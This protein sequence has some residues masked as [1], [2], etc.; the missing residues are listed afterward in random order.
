MTSRNQATPIFRSNDGISW[1]TNGYYVPYGS[2]PYDTNPYDLTA[3]YIAALSL[4]SVAFGNGVFVAVGQ[5]IVTSKDTYIWQSTYKFPTVGWNNATLVNELYGVTYVTNNNFTGFVAVGKG[6]TYDYSSGFS[7]IIDVGIILTSIDGTNWNQ[8]VN[9]SN[10]GLYGVSS[11][12]TKIVAVGEDGII[13]YS[14]NGT[15]WFGITQTQ[16]LSTISIDNVINVDSTIGLNID[17]AIRFNNSFS[18]VIAN[19][20][21]Y[22]SSIVSNTQVK[23]KTGILD[24]VLTLTV[25]SIPSNTYL[26]KYPL[27]N[28]L[29]DIIF[30]NNFFLAVGDGGI[31]RSSLDGF[32]WTDETSG[33]TENLNGITYKVVASGLYL[34]LD[35]LPANSYMTTENDL[36]M[37]T[38]TTGAGLPNQV[39]FVVVGDNNTIIESIDNGITWKSIS[40]FRV[41]ATLYDVQGESFDSGYSPEE[42]VSGVV[43]DNLTMVIT[44]K[45][46][47]NWPAYEYA[48]VGYN[49]VSIELTPINAFQFVYSFRDT[50]Q[51]PAQISLFIID[52]D[53]GLCT[54]LLPSQYTINWISET[55]TLATPLPFF[56]IPSKLRIDVYEVGNGNQLIRSSTKTDPILLNSVTGW[57][58]IFLNC[59]YSA[60]IF[61]GS[62]VLRPDE[63]VTDVIATRTQSS[64]DSIFVSDASK[65]IINGV[66]YFQGT[67]FGNILEDTPYYVKSI[68][69]LTNSI[70]I[71]DNYSIA[72]GVAGAIFNLSNA[73]GSMG[74]IIASGSSS[75]WTDPIILHNGVK[76]ALGVVGNI[77]RTKSSNNAITTNSTAGLIENSPIK[78]ANYSFGVIVPQQTYYIKNILDSNEFTI[79]STVINGIAGPVLPLTDESGT[80]TFITSDF[81]F[82]QVPNGAGTN[83][84]FSRNDY[85]KTYDYI[86]Y[87]V[88][89]ESEPIQYGYTIP[90]F[91]GFT[92]IAGQ[93]IYN[94]DNFVGGLNPNN[95]VVEINGVRQLNNI[96][97]ISGNN[98]NIT[99]LNPPNNGD[100]ITITSYSNTDRQYLNTQFGITGSPLIEFNGVTVADTYN[101]TYIFD[102]TQNAQQLVNLKQYQIAYVND[103]EWPV[104]GDSTDFSLLGATTV[105]VGSLV[106][107]TTYVIQSL[108]LTGIT[109]FTLLGAQ[110]NT[111]GL[112]FTATATGLITVGNF[113]PSLSYKIVSPGT[114]NFTLLGAVDNNIGTEFIAIGTGVYAAGQIIGGETYTIATQGSTDFTL[115]G[116]ANNNVGTTFI[117]TGSG[118]GTGT[119]I[120]GN[121]TATQGT[122]FTWE[123]LFVANG[124][125]SAETGSVVLNGNGFDSQLVEMGYLVYNQVYTIIDIGTTTNAQWNAIAGTSDIS[126]SSLIVGTYYEISVL[127][128][129]NWNF[130][131]DP[132][133]RSWGMGSPSVGDTF[134]A[135][136]N[137][138]GGGF[139]TIYYQVGYEFTCV[140]DGYNYGTG[141]VYGAGLFDG[142]INNLVCDANTST[143]ILTINDPILFKEPVIGGVLPEITY[144]VTQIL[145]SKIFQISE[146]VGGSTFIVSNDTGAMNSIINTIQVNNITGINNTLTPVLGT[147]YANATINTSVTMNS[148][149]I[150]GTVLTVG[151]VTGT[152]QLGMEL[153]GTGVQSGTIIIS[154]V[155]GSGSG[156]V[157]TVNNNQTVFSTTIT[158]TQ[159][160][161]ELDDTIGFITGQTVEFKSPYIDVGTLEVTKEY[162]IFSLGTTTN[163]QWNTIAGTTGVIYEVGMTFTCSDPGIGFGTGIVLLANF[164]GLNCLGQVYFVY[165]KTPTKLVVADENNNII[166]LSNSTFSPLIKVVTGGV[167]S[168]RITTLLPHNFLTNQYVRIDGVEGAIQLNNNTYFVHVISEKVFD[169]YFTPYNFAATAV[170][171]YVEAVSTYIGGGFVW[172][173]TLFTISDTATYSTSN[174]NKRIY[175]KSTDNFIIGTPVYFSQPGN[176]IGD[177]IIG[178]LEMGREYYIREIFDIEVGVPPSALILGAT[179]KITE[180]G[181]A[182]WNFINGTSG[183]QYKIGSIISVK[184]TVST[185]TGLADSVPSFTVN[186]ERNGSLFSVSTDYFTTFVTQW[187]QTNVDRLWVTINGL[188]VPS[189]SLRINANNNLSILYPINAGDEVTI[190]SMVPNATPNEEIYILN[191][192]QT[193]EPS[194]YRNNRYRKTYV[195]QTLYPMI[196][197]LFV[198]DVTRVS[199][200]YV[201]NTVAPT[202]TNNIYTIGLIA[203]KTIIA[204]VTVYNNTK[205]LLLDQDVYSVQIV[206]SS[207]MLEIL[208]GSYIDVG[209]NLTITTLEGR[210]ILVN[211][212]IIQF[213]GIDFANN[214][215]LGLSRAS[216][217]TGERVIIPKYSVVYGLLSQDK[218]SD[219]QYN[220]TWNS[221][222]FNTVEGDPLQISTTDPALFLES[223]S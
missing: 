172:L 166:P 174:I 25:G 222:T 45:P 134:Q 195:T 184:N 219:N 44:T 210:T 30:A 190:G 73:T 110:T 131:S 98:Q 21:Y 56:P 78:F 53:T 20:T 191:V 137:S 213:S 22:I 139:V 127:G 120:Q 164:G 5:E 95:A 28:T 17:D 108:G 46:G 70:T 153:T 101:D 43:K 168:I 160:C 75:V 63:V 16:V 90:E 111:Y 136:G 58:E 92:A 55:V 133:S 93:S 129:T 107:G 89:G 186:V 121:G 97:I 67:T 2:G 59:N 47:S 206:D 221:Y 61:N 125:P 197:V 161:I 105:N 100:I 65:F 150:S 183:V 18:S 112:S 72:T 175:V 99:F 85:D 179:Y 117:A 182:N 77:F 149:S 158:G 106:I 146:S 82:T 14:L 122:G 167:P 79:S 113:T 148:S 42:L 141:L 128:L 194:V 12:G 15:V 211:G 177:L 205:S 203:E 41:P 103:N 124:V 189:S 37:T 123:K 69:L 13:Y 204:S 8:V 102:E 29:N 4:N 180:L 140:N 35:G 74:V 19:T 114:T 119:A 145:N 212:E 116:A 62:G 50:V 218:L 88:F 187:E 130:I 193:N 132:A 32:T 198:D 11:D 33:T 126:S 214:A 151:T 178:N 192:N 91:Q 31:I 9:L 152:I 185:G 202:P 201:E 142:E 162:Y 76:L 147:S 135:I 143:S 104:A 60:D 188:R 80:G 109:D 68:S 216:F 118:T 156:S 39:L 66:I 157:W 223:T 169:I 87:T 171:N 165:Y 48:N 220:L 38:E 86:T 26:E 1:T 144:F 217:G 96:Y 71:S 6:Q 154:N 52:R 34:E 3:I 94:L 10:K 155:S 170:N 176:L 173:D 83:L 138:G 40:L 209:D 163:N 54:G 181:N 81:A 24:P 57:Q 27:T 215:L 196:D 64:N 199:K 115:I 159:N 84:V 23:I 7:E 49:V 208:D 51:Y 207:P 36:T 200:V